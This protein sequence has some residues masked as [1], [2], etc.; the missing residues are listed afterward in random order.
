MRASRKITPFPPP[1]QKLEDRILAVID[2]LLACHGYEGLE[3]EEVARE[4]GLTKG[5][6]YLQYQSRQDLLLSHVDWIARR[7][8]AGEKAIASQRNTTPLEK[9]RQLLFHRVMAHFDAVQHFA[10]SLEE[11]WRDLGPSLLARREETML[12]EAE[13]IQWLLDEGQETGLLRPHDSRATALAL[14]TLTNA[15]LPYNLAPAQFVRRRQLEENIHR[16]IDLLIDGI[17]TRSRGQRRRTA[18]DF[19]VLQA[20]R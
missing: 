10:E 18:T 13:V 1:E 19:G 2:R 17:G 15:L 11:I 20:V 14:L 4:V 12:R 5:A 9:I 6:L 7:I 16:A 3:L 8:L